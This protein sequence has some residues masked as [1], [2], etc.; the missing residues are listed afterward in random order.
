M[1]SVL[2]VTHGNLAE[3]LVKKRKSINDLVR[4]DLTSLLQNPKLSAADKQR[5]QQ[6]ANAEGSRDSD[7]QSNRKLLERAPQHQPHDLLP[8]GSQRHPHPDLRRALGDGIRGDGIEADGRQHE[9]DQR[10]D[11][12]AKVLPHTHGDSASRCHHTGTAAQRQR[13]I[14]ET[15]LNAEP[16]EHAERSFK[17]TRK[18][19]RPPRTPH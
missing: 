3:E 15:I 18:T 8:L 1:V 4:G 7:A 10:E 13:K 5:L 16:A 12:E 6:P 14:A 2:V 9:R 11:G 17:K 19:L